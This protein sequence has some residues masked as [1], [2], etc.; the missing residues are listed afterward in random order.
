MNKPR[1]VGGLLALLRPELLMTTAEI[2]LDPA[3]AAAAASTTYLTVEQAAGL[4]STS[5]TALRARCRRY[6]RREGREVISRLGGGIVAVKLGKSW[7]VR[8]PA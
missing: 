3:P 5:P 7:R 1:S 6:A 4:L 8:L 2:R